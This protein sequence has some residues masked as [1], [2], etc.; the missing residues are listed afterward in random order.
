MQYIIFILCINA[1]MDSLMQEPLAPKKSYTNQVLINGIIGMSLGVGTGI[2][3]TMG[4]KAYDE[5]KESMT[6]Q[7]ALDNWE[8]VRLFD[9]I[10]NVCAV[11]ALAF[12]LR[13]VYYQF[14]NIKS[15]QSESLTPVINLHYA[16]CK[17]WVVGIQK[18]L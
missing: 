13:A 17:K 11:G 8:K 4:N 6:M 15:S 18:R 10:R 9:N 2:F 14:K 12:I 3:Y 16:N 7:S 5:Y 1:S